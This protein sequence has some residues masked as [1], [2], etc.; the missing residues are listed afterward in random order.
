MLGLDLDAGRWIVIA[1]VISLGVFGLRNWLPKAVGR[2]VAER[3]SIV[4]P[5]LKP[6]F[7]E[8]A[9]RRTGPDLA[10]LANR[11]LHDE[12]LAEA[13]KLKLRARSGDVAERITTLHR[14]INKTQDALTARPE[15]YD[16]T[17]LLAELNLDLA[18]LD[19]SPASV[20]GLEQAAQLFEKASS[21]RL[22][23][24]DNYVGRG[25]SYLQMTR[26]DPDYSA[27]YGEKAAMAF[28]AGHARVQQ[29]VWVLRGWGLAI[30]RVARSAEADEAKVSEL[31]AEY[32]GAL[33]RHRGG[34]H[35]LFD[36]YGGVRAAAELVW[37]DVPTLRDVY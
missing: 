37:I 31:E 20:A 12:M 6:T 5:A 9:L 3:G 8:Q 21:F 34:Q 30:D 36:W 19:A 11:Q 29:N 13:I 25:W 4:G 35:D 18:L 10:N 24:I 7:E 22:G 23:V 1:V 17:K 14:A 15:S 28:A 32:R 16:G 2:R 26:V 33:G 27:T